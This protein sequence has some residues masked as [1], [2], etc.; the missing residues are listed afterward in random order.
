MELPY[1]FSARRFG[2]LPAANALNHTDV[3]FGG[4][5]LCEHFHR[6][7][8]SK[9]TPFAD[10][11]ALNPFQGPRLDPHPVS[12]FK[13]WV[14]LNRQWAVDQTAY[15]IDFFLWYIRWTPCPGHERVNAWRGEDVQHSV[16]ATSNEHIIGEKRQ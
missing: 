2:P 11:Y 10:E 16:E 14:R 1:Q 15:S 13:I 3:H 12:A 7:D 5:R 4:G 8:Q 9:S 6:K